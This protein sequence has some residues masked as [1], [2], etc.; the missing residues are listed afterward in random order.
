MDNIRATVEKMHKLAEIYTGEKLEAV[1]IMEGD[2]F[3]DNPKNWSLMCLGE[4]IKRMAEADY[5][6]GIR[7]VDEYWRGCIIEVDIA[8]R[9]G[10]PVIELDCMNLLMPDGD[11]VLRQWWAEQEKCCAT[12]VIR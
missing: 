5:F 12:E 9:Y 2:L 3:D 1:N 4:S 10:I 8:R 11:E 6:V 7:W